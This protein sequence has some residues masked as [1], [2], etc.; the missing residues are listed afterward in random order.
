MQIKY[1]VSSMIFWW[2]ENPVSFEQECDFLRA[3]GYGIEL[4]SNI[5]GHPECRY[6]RRN[7]QRLGEATKGMTV[8]MHGRV[9]YPD[10][11]QW[12]EQIECAK[13]LDAHI[14]TDLRNFGIPEGAEVNGC[15]FSAE[16]LKIAAEN[17]VRIC[18]ETG[19][20]DKMLKL[21]EKF[22]SLR[23]C[24][25]TGFANID[26][27]YTFKQYVDELGA[28]TAHLHLCDNY[29]QTDE[30][31]PPGLRKGIPAENW[32]YLR[33]SLEKYDNTVIA[34][35]EMSPCSPQVMLRQASEFI[36][37]ELNWPGR[38]E[39]DYTTRPKTG[40]L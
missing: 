2:R 27:V 37:E 38:P 22:D 5:K 39:K 29:G 12:R 32:E 30:H 7:W 36:F 31:E 33:E 19:R 21:A 26:P 3:K 18:L 6:E 15:D 35:F 13:F 23:F 11:E 4:R 1:V 25:D 17:G 9:D 40:K 10:L 20:L 24:L 8:T 34:S 16:I 28:K 14:V